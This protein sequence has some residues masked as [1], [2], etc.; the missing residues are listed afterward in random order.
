M[1]ESRWGLLVVMGRGW[2]GE[3]RG[4][5]VCGVKARGDGDRVSFRRGGV[6]WQ[7]A[8]AQGEMSHSICPPLPPPPLT[9][10][11]GC[12]LIFAPRSSAPPLRAKADGLPR[13]VVLCC[14]HRTACYQ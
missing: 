2:A 10:L 11:N 9:E 4:L 1:G 5:L 3:E 14:D 13:V 8:L 7:L 12:Y 6:R